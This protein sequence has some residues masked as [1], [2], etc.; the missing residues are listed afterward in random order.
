MIEPWEKVLDVLRSGKTRGPGAFT[1]RQLQEKTGLSWGQ[2]HR[3]LIKLI[4]DG[5]HP[6]GQERLDYKRGRP[7]I[8]WWGE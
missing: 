6:I 4:A 2:V 1:H 7:Y 3:A 8:Y 5:R